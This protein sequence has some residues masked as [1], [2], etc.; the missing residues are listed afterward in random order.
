MGDLPALIQELDCIR[1]Q[2]LCVSESSNGVDN[3][4]GFRL[5]VTLTALIGIKAS[6][7]SPVFTHLEDPQSF[8]TK[9]EAW[10]FRF[11]ALTF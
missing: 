3:P 6:G 8:E 2:P 11:A 4:T 1:K 9:R 7:E 5:T 10:K